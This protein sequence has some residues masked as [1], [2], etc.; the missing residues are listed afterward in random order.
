M[1]VKCGLPVFPIDI[2]NAKVLIVGTFPSPISLECGEYYKNND[3]L[4]WGMM[5]EVLKCPNLKMESYAFKE[6]LLKHNHIILWDILKSC[7]RKGALDKSIIEETA[8]NNDFS[9]ILKNNK[10][11]III[12][13]GVVIRS[14]KTKKLGAKGWFIKFNGEICDF[15]KKYNVKV[16][17]LH[18]TS[19]SAKKWFNIS[20]WKENIRPYIN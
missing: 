6:Q 7:E 14:K 16:I 1:T 9:D 18:S 10:I 19:P 2:D 20:E 12:I 11:R 4:F 3:N 17:A 15:E 8:D 13:N 5:A